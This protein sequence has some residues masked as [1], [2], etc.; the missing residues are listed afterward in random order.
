M[1]PDMSIRPY[2]HKPL[3]QLMAVS[4]MTALLAGCGGGVSLGFGTG[5]GVG[6]GVGVG[7]GFG[8]RTAPSIALTTSTTS[9]QRGRSVR[10]AAAAADESGV[11]SV[12]FLRLDGE[13]AVVLATV[14]RAPFELD[15][16]APT[17]GPSVLVVFARATDNAGNRADSAPIA[18]T[19]TP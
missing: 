13:T 2:A 14:G 6:V 5:S 8:D 9:V 10:L 11:E 7:S 15:V 1:I 19:L 18:I 17:D 4:V 3:G 16:I 12:S